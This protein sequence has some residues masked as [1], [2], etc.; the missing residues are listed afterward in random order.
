[1]T[2]LRV[3]KEIIEDVDI[4]LPFYYVHYVDDG[5]I[6]GKVEE[7]CSFTVRKTRGGPAT[8]WEFKQDVRGAHYHADYCVERYC[9]TE[10]E[11]EAA[12]AEAKKFAA[13][14]AQ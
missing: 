6:Y 5:V 9:S 7:C 14:F 3:K 2:K 1:M 8:A 11:F 4:E 12:L 13:R 10:L